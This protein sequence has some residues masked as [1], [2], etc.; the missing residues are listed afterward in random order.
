MKVFSTL[1]SKVAYYGKIAWKNDIN[2]AI[3]KMNR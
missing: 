1:E 2:F 3:K